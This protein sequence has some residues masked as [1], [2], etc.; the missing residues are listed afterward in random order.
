MTHHDF[1][2]AVESLLDIH[3]GTG[4]GRPPMHGPAFTQPRSIPPVTGDLRTISR[5]ERALAALA[6][7]VR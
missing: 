5:R 3:M 2:E 1:T 4:R 7:V 6:R